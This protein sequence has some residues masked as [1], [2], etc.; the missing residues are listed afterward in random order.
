V[1]LALSVCCNNA[2]LKRSIAAALQSGDQELEALD[3]G[4]HLRR[5]VLWILDEYVSDLRPPEHVDGALVL[6]S[7][8]CD[9]EDEELRRAQVA[10]YAGPGSGTDD[11]MRCLKA[12]LE[13]QFLALRDRLPEPWNSMAP[14][15]RTAVR[16]VLA[17]EPEQTVAA[18]RG[19]ALEALRE[20]VS[21]L[22]SMLGASDPVALRP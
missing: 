17:G 14:R 15:E 7:L 12:A 3:D 9:F 22:R 16:C 6:L 11:V 20:R 13:G 19:I 8:R 10:S 5:V 2:L 4:Q 1:P 18:R 21:A